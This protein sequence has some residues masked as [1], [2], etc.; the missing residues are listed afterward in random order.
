MI[1]EDGEVAPPGVTGE[2]SVRRR[3]EWF[4]AKDLGSVDEEGY[5][6]YGGRADDVIISAGWTISPLEVERA[7]L[8]HP[9]VT[10]AAVIGT[11]DEVRGQVVTAFIVSDR[12]EDEVAEDDLGGRIVSWPLRM[13][14]AARKPPPR[15]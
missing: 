14:K 15:R 8:S 5:F 9:D 12:G 2:I 4:G 11:P 10:E 7:L 1:A 13:P 3:G 6:H